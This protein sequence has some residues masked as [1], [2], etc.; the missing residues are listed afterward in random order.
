VDITRDE[1]A[2]AAGSS[3]GNVQNMGHEG[4]ALDVM[5]SGAIRCAGELL[6]K[7][8]LRG[9]NRTWRLNGNKS[10]HSRHA[11]HFPSGFPR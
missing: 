1:V 8:E 11:R 9:P 7:G 2:A 5:I 4:K 6:E 10:R 3:L